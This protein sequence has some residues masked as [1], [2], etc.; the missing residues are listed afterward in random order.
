ML[1]HM[2]MHTNTTTCTHAHKHV[3]LRTCRHTHAQEFLVSIQAET[4]KL[5]HLN[6]SSSLNPRHLSLYLE[7]QSSQ[8]E[9]KPKPSALTIGPWPGKYN[10]NNLPKGPREGIMKG[11][12]DEVA[13]NT[14]QCSSLASLA[15]VCDV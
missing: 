1:M 3:H 6:K 7:T 5:N 2:Q 8:Q 12:F 14:H 11:R 4:R 15:P 13:S 9:L 10:K